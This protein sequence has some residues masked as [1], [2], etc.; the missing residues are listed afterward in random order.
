MRNVQIRGIAASSVR[1]ERRYH[2]VGRAAA[3]SIPFADLRLMRLDFFAVAAV[4]DIPDPARAAPVKTTGG[5]L[6]PPGY[7]TARL[8]S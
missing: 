3:A 8:H 1:S 5:A 7:E 6:S 4:G 2:S